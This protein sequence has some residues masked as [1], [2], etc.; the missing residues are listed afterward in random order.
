[1]RLAMARSAARMPSTRTTAA[2]CPLSSTAAIS[3]PD[4]FRPGNAEQL[5]QA[6]D[7]DQPPGD[8]APRS[9]RKD[10]ARSGQRR[11]GGALAGSGTVWRVNSEVNKLRDNEECT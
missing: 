10:A 1:M 11:R 8:P 4:T 2:A 3:I 5:M 7:P 6:G 9:P